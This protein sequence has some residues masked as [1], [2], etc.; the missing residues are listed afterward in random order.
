VAVADVT[1]NIPGTYRIYTDT[2]N[3]VSFSASGTF[4]N[5]GPQAIDL[6]GSGTPL[7]AGTFTFTMTGGTTTCTFQLNFLPATIQNQDYFPL[8]QNSWWTYDSNLATDTLYKYS[9]TIASIGP[10]TY[11]I[12]QIGSPGPFGSNALGTAA[13]RKSG[14]DYFEYFTVDSFTTIA[15]DNPLAG[16]VIFLKE[17]APVGTSWQSAEFTGTENGTPV[18]IRYDYTI[19]SVGG[20]YTVNGNVYNN[21]IKV[22]S[23]SQINSNNTVYNPD[24]EMESYYARG[25]GLIEFRLR[26]S[27]SPTWFEVQ[28]LRYYT[29]N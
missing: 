22:F 12:F 16:E 23:Q 15:L 13:F 26:L 20:T 25:V 14:S 24:L 18:K 6:I 10:N 8:T 5:T 17:N 2:V 21:V 27:G 3:G 19:Q 4:G 11:R 28:S 9:S 7:A 1:V 29:V